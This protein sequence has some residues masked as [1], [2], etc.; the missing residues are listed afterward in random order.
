MWTVEGVFWQGFNGLSFLVLGHA[1][2][3]AAAFDVVA[4]VWVHQP[5]PQPENIA[6]AVQRVIYRVRKLEKKGILR[7]STILNPNSYIDS[8]AEADP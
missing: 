7:S 5:M 6:A 3:V 8:S 2:V 4:V 1:S